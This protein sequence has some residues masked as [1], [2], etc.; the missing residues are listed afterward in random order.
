MSP[1]T[2]DELDRA[3]RA[4]NANLARVDQEQGAPRRAVCLHPD[5]TVTLPEPG[6]TRMECDYCPAWSAGAFGRPAP[7]LMPHT[8]LLDQG[9]Q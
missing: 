9:D 6:L 4:I 1:L 8:Y 3:E 5:R 7:D 2:P